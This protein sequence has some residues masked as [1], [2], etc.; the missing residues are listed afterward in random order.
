LEV[1]IAGGRVASDGEKDADRAAG[2][3][4][5]SGVDRGDLLWPKRSAI[6]MGMGGPALLS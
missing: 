1:D 4:R 6:G 5:I 3:L 2:E